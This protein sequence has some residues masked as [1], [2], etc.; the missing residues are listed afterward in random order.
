MSSESY[1]R[2]DSSRR[3]DVYGQNG[4]R[5]EYQVE[6]PVL[7][8]RFHLPVPDAGERQQRRG[9]R[10]NPSQGPAQWGSVSPLP[11]DDQITLARQYHEQLVAFYFEHA[12]QGVTVPIHNALQDRAREE[13]LY[14]VR[15]KQLE[16]ELAHHQRQQHHPAHVP[17]DSHQPTAIPLEGPHYTQMR[18]SP[19]VS[20]HPQLPPRPCAPPALPAIPLHS[21]DTSAI[22]HSGGVGLTRSTS[23]GTPIPL[24]NVPLP[25]PPA[26]T[27]LARSAS[28]VSPQNSPSRLAS[29]V[30]STLPV[31]LQDA[32]AL[33]TFTFGDGDDDL[34]ILSAPLINPQPQQQPSVPSTVR[35]H[36]R[37]DPSHPSHPLYHP[38]STLSSLPLGLDDHL[39]CPGCGTLIIG[40]AMMALDAKWHPKCFVCSVPE[41]GAALEHIMFAEHHG[42]AYCMVHHD[43]VGDC[44][45]ISDCLFANFAPSSNSSLPTDAFNARHQSP[46]QISSLCLTKDWSLRVPART[47]RCIFS[48]PTVGTRLWIPNPCHWDA[49]VP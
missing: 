47:T 37:F 20:P 36:P 26:A 3:E 31:A 18:V 27:P 28:D 10:S 7:Q 19:N 35:L 8:R 21:M 32:A 43:E 34:V 1:G 13:A 39:Q 33:P 49:R 38:T 22:G 16:H 15:Q 5:V 9:D 24:R 25:A 48:A 4:E 45:A 40:R 30:A 29:K 6:H 44:S 14:W 23:L 12:A 11:L 46:K 2:N 41:C 42:K 17:I